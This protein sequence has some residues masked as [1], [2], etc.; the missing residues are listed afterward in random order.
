MGSKLLDVASIGGGPSIYAS[1]FRLKEI[2]EEDGVGNVAGTELT[3][4]KRGPD[5][6][7]PATVYPN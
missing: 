6:E 7:D 4:L 5:N 3:L 1:V 2:F